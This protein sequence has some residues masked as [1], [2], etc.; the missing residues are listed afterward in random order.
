MEKGPL[1]PLTST[2]NPDQVIASDD[3]LTLGAFQE[4]IE[5]HMAA[6][7]CFETLIEKGILR[8]AN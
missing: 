8:R 1:P 6:I 7:H 4:W 2:N 5:K 3:A